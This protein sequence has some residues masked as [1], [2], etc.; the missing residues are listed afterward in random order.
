MKKCPKCEREH[1]NKDNYCREDGTKLVN[2]S[3]PKCSACGKT[4]YCGKYCSNCGVKLGE[5][6]IASK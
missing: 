5:N 6:K 1:F 2:F 4:I 3:L